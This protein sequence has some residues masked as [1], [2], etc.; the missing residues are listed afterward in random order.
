MNTFSKIRYD[1]I[2]LLKGIA[3][4]LVVMGHFIQFNTETYHSNV[5]YRLIY[6]FHMELF[7]FLSGYIVLK[8]TIIK[9]IESTKIFIR[10]RFISLMLPYFSWGILDYYILNSPKNVSFI[11]KI[12]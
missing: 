4:L 2:D 11:N 6:S 8:T 3:I 1:N 10:K 12:V 9:D 7:M 5:G